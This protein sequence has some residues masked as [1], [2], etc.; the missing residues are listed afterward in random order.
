MKIFIL[1][2]FAF[3]LAVGLGLVFV[4]PMS[5]SYAQ[6]PP[7]STPRS[8]T[9]PGEYI[10]TL[11]P[12]FVGEPP[13]GD[14]GLSNHSLVK[15]DQNI[16]IEANEAE[17]LVEDQGA[18]VTSVYTRALNGFA[19]EGV[20]DVTP[21]VQDPAIQSV[22]PN[23]RDWP[24]RQYMPAG[25]DRTDLDKAVTASSR[26]D[27]RESKP[28]IDV[29][30]IDQPV[31][32]DHPDLNVVQRVNFIQCGETLPSG[33]V[34]QCYSTTEGGP[35]GTHVAGSVAARDNLGGVV[36]GLPGARII[37]LGICS[38]NAG[39]DGSDTLAAWDYV[40][41]NA[42]TIEIATMSVGCGP[43]N[44]AGCAISST[45]QTAA[46][47]MVNAGVTFF[48]SAGNDNVN[49]D[50]SR[51]CG[52]DA[53]ICVSALSDS[54]G[55]C[56]STGPGFGSGYNVFD[57]DVRAGFSNFGSDV[58]IMAPGVNIL[59]TFPGDA[60]SQSAINA[61][62]DNPY[63]GASEQGRYGYASGTSMATPLAAGIGALIKSKNP[64]WTP[65]QIKTDMQAKAY[66]QTQSCDGF[67]KGGLV[68]GAN[69]ESSE[70]LLYAQP[71]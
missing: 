4:P 59:S 55:K 50:D 42:A 53:A 68:S 33:T 37:S 67:G 52:A 29:A 28:N 7:A 44:S 10:V 14:L 64:S 61:Q 47:N 5:Y 36:G 13:T 1:S 20:Q 70:K 18:N 27:S 41:S 2:A 54:D 16:L 3:L 9:I 26:P 58:D 35:H 69:S 65:S 48:V 63:I 11:K 51:Y 66:S 49:A 22:E 62:T 57:D 38:V 12:E 40:T 56:G 43:A 15:Q 17:E 31:D 30:V 34:V 25:I 60:N 39:C 24:Q 21:L 23:W 19:I 71:Y 32:P 8:T 46:T 45:V 6:A